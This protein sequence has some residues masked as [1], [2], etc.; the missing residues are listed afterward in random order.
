MDGRKWQTTDRWTKIKLQILSA[1]TV[2][3]GIG[4]SLM[5]T[6]TIDVIVILVRNTI[7]KLIIGTVVK[8][9]NGD[10]EMDLDKLIEM[11]Q[12][13]ASIHQQ[14]FDTHV[15]Y[16]GVT[17]EEIYADDTEIIDE[18]LSNHQ[19]MADTHKE[20]AKYLNQIRDVK[21][22]MNKWADNGDNNTLDDHIRSL[23]NLAYILDIP[24]R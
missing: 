5:E 15:L 6:R 19:Y 21:R 8:D 18:Q 2:S 24:L 17:L 9:L 3:I 16:N 10:N 13:K 20:I 4:K 14:V 12:E 7:L 22:L 1:N 11:E 23:V